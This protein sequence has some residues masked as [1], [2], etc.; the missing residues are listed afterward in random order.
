MAKYDFSVHYDGPALENNS[1]P[2][3]DLAPSLLSLSEAFQVIQRLNHPDQ[4]PLSLNINATKEGS[5]VAE[6]FLVNGQNLIKDAVNLLNGD[7]ST[8]FINLT[9]YVEIFVGVVDVIKKVADHHIKAKEEKQ[10]QVIITLDD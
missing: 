4:L 5:F 6:L 9:E 10:G 7:A 3:Q 2:V 1:I 8:A